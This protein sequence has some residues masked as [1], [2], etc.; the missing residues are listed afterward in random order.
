MVWL[1]STICFGQAADG[2][3]S[4]GWRAAGAAAASPQVSNA[5][6]SARAAG[7]AAPA[8]E[9]LLFA[10]DPVPPQPAPQIGAA[11]STITMPGADAAPGGGAAAL[12]WLPHAGEECRPVELS[13]PAAVEVSAGPRRA[14][15]KDVPETP[16]AADAPDSGPFVLPAGMFTRTAV[17]LAS[18]S[19]G[20]AS[21]T[22]A[23]PGTM[24]SM[25]AE[26]LRMANIEVP[27]PLTPPKGLEG[28]LPPA[29]ERLPTAP[30]PS[31]EDECRRPRSHSL[32][33]IS[34]DIRP[35]VMPGEQVPPADC[36]MISTTFASR[37]WS[38]VT[39]T[40]TASASCNKPLYFDDVQLENYGHAWAPYLQPLIS[41][42]HFFATVP[43]LPYYMG[44]NPPEECIYTLGEYRPGNCAPYMLDPFPWSTR[45]A[46]YE[47]TMWTALP[48]VF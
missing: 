34:I 29:G 19:E 25:V 31:V 3:E 32:S 48:F 42:V 35:K 22:A 8:T 44:V 43:L 47:A 21:G 11:Q 23:G 46:I 7:P 4:P 39:F 36:T 1:V 38:P 5:A 28:V 13:I 20:A 15:V 41:S 6:D 24:R 10:V 30:A 33:E 16:P 18:A 37:A 14:I 2:D 45:G 40:W 26:P 27:R 12:R 9:G 17:V